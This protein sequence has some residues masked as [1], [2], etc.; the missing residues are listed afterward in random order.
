MLYEMKE[1]MKEQQAQSDREKEQMTIQEQ[2]KLRLLNQQLLTQVAALQ[3]NPV[4][5]KGDP[6]NS[7][8][9]NLRTLNKLIHSEADRG[10]QTV[11]SPNS[12]YQD[13]QVSSLQRDLGV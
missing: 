7:R 13:P 6:E 1:Q 5:T 8:S 10:G 3:N 9:S 11:G 12:N 4:Q 2:D